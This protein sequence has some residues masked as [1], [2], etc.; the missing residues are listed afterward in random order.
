[1]ILDGITFAERLRA[2][3]VPVPDNTIRI[4]VQAEPDS[5]ALVVYTVGLDDTV[6]DIACEA[7]RSARAMSLHIDATPHDSGSDRVDLSNEAR[8]V[9]R[10]SSSMHIS[11]PPRPGPIS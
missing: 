1:M 6:A 7:A 10:D 3:G 11:S 2:A 4:E 9:N 5:V 8:T